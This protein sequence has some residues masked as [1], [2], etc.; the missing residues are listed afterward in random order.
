MDV[1]AVEDPVQRRALETMIKTYGQ[2]PRQ[3]FHTAHISRGGPK[4]IIEGELPSAV[5]LLVQLA[6]RESRDQS[7]DIIHPVRQN[8]GLLL[9]Q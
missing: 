2:T 8:P 1:S 6:F 7:K 5:G 3:L 4:L 9:E